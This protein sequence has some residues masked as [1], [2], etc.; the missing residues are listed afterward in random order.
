MAQTKQLEKNIPGAIGLVNKLD[1]NAKI[2][3]IE[4][5]V[6]SI[7]GLARNA[8]LTAI[9]SKITNISSLIKKQ[10]ITQNLLKRKRNLLIII[11][12]NMLLLQNLTNFR[13]KFFMQ[14]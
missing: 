5:K 10:I 2:A 8:A 6:P 13:Q 9:E 3:E 1:Y 7:S 12:T 11:T 4:N 14:D